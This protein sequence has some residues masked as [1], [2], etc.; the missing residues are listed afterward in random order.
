MLSLQHHPKVLVTMSD[1]D[2]PGIS[3]QA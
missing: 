2:N 1:L 3:P